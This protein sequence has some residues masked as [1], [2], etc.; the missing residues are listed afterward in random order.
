MQLLLLY[1]LNALRR[2]THY[3]TVPVRVSPLKRLFIRIR[4]QDFP[5]LLSD[6]AMTTVHYQYQYMTST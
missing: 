6:Q 4:Q 3:G 2:F 5:P 1:Q